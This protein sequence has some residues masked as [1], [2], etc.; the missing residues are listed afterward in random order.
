MTYINS[1][2]NSWEKGFE[3]K[4]VTTREEFLE[5]YL[6]HYLIIIF[7]NIILYLINLFQYDLVGNN[8]DAIYNFLEFLTKS[9]SVIFIF[10]Q[11]GSIII[12]IPLSIRS[13]RNAKSNW[14]WTFLNFINPVGCILIY[15]F[16][17]KLHN[18]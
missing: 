14:K 5:Y 2:I 3:Y 16:P 17:L 4:G 1:F 12:Q 10:Y 6:I 8:Y 11:L 18:N 7:K 9:I 15:L 13:L